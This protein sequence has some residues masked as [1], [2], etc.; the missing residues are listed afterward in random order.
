MG[1]R[2]LL[3]ERFIRLSL[4]TDVKN[5]NSAPNFECNSLYFFYYIIS[6]NKSKWNTDGC[7]R[8]TLCTT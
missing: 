6:L 1:P 8:K 2:V 5:Q 7:V 4:K 3:L